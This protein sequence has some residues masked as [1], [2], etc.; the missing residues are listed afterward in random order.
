MLRYL[1]P[2]AVCFLASLLLLACS[3]SP[4]SALTPTAVGETVP[5][6]EAPPPVQPSQ[7]AAVQEATAPAATSPAV[8]VKATPRPEMA[9]TDPS[10]VLLAAGKPQLVEFFAFW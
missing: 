3:T 5:S 2:L 6:S 1:N 4:P 8:E 10:Q 7:P 9:A